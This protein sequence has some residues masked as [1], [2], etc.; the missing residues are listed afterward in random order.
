MGRWVGNLVG[1]GGGGGQPCDRSVMN[2][3]QVPNETLLQYF[4][5]HGLRYGLALKG[6]VALAAEWLGLEAIPGKWR[7]ALL[8]DEVVSLLESGK[9]GVDGLAIGGCFY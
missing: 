2:T 6:G 4:G 5:A 9:L 7:Q 1:G 3:D 8:S